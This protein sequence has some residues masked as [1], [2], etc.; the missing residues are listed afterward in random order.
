MVASVACESTALESKPLCPA[1]PPLPEPLPALLP[2]PLPALLPEL[3][4]AL[5]PEESTTGESSAAS[6]VPPSAPAPPPPN[7]SNV[8]RIEHAVDAAARTTSAARPRL[9]LLPQ[10]T[11]FSP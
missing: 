5:L 7:P 9:A 11:N 2:E 8:V 10:D 1:S 6:V 3:L 4:P